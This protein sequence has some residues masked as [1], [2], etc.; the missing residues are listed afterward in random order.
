MNLPADRAGSP[1]FAGETTPQTT[2]SPSVSVRKLSG[3]VACGRFSSASLDPMRVGSE[4]LEDLHERGMICQMGL[5][6]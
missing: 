6:R 5:K 1:Q 2:T 3:R 4:R